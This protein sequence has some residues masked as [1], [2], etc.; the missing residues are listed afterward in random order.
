MLDVRLEVFDV[1][2]YHI[3]A[4]VS[5]TYTPPDPPL[6]APRKSSFIITTIILVHSFDLDPILFITLLLCTYGLSEASL[7]RFSTLKF[8]FRQQLM[9]RGFRSTHR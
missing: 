9:H 1:V 3:G 6:L 2:V 7:C 5:G 8:C 4:V